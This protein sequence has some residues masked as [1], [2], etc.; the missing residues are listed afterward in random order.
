MEKQNPFSKCRK[1]TYRDDL[2]LE[3]ELNTKYKKDFNKVQALTGTGLPKEIA[4]K[5]VK[6][7]GTYFNCDFCYD[8]VI[9]KTHV[10]KMLHYGTYGFHTVCSEECYKNIS[11]Y[12]YERDRVESME[13]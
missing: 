2:P 3:H 4:M 6:M 7:A 11:E 8:N 1:C 5:I 9:C 12:Y 13:Q 10:N